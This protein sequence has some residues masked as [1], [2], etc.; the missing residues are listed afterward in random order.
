[1]TETE[2]HVEHEHAE[3]ESI[4]EEVAEEIR[5]VLEEANE[6]AERMESIREVESE[7]EA[8]QAQVESHGH[9]EYS[10]IGHAHPEYD[11]SE[12]FAS[13]ESRIE[14]IERGMEE[15]I[16]EPV[17]EEIEPTESPRETESEERRR[18]HKFGRR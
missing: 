7:T 8:L 15:S 5:E 14:N 2:V 12:R 6:D 11:H 10:P 18:K 17:V 9:S 3:G 4:A 13:L 16:E 1:M